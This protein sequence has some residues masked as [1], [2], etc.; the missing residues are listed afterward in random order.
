MELFEKHG[1]KI[2]NG[3]RYYEFSMEKKIYGYELE[4]SIPY[5]FKH[6]DFV[7][8]TSKWNQ[9]AFGIVKHFNELNPR[10]EE[11]LL[12]IQYDFSKTPVF[13]KDKRINFTQYKNL[14]L[15]TNHSSGH[16]FKSVQILLK[17]FD[18]NL[19]D[20]Y[21][22]IKRHIKSEPNDIKSYFRNQTILMY[23]KFF[24]FLGYEKNKISTIVG[25]IDKINIYLSKMNTSYNDFYLFDDYY[26]FT[27][28]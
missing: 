7:V 19:S 25:N 8:Q 17:F 14:Y 6:K 20:C 3:K 15:N 21:F 9:L 12:Q 24:E 23:G 18:V 4:N 27:N 16:S 1:L 2:L 28:Y 11:E 26:Y 22:L 13:S 5:L 10:T